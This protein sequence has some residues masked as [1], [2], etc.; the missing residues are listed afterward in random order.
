MFKKLLALMI[1][2]IAFGLVSLLAVFAL[3]HTAYLTPSAQWLNQQWLASPF[4]FKQVRYEYPLHITF[5]EPQW[6]TGDQPKLNAQQLDIWFHPS[7]Y[8]QGRWQ[9]RQLL[10]DQLQF[11]KDESL[12]DLELAE[13]TQSIQLHHLALERFSLHTPE[14]SIQE[15]NVQIKAPRWTQSLQQLPYGDIQLSATQLQWQHQ[16]LT[17]PLLDIRYQE[18]DSTVYGFSFRWQGGD[19]SGQAEHYPQGWS[20]INT[21][22]Q[23]LNWDQQKQQAL[24]PDLASLNAHI[25]HLNSLDILQSQLTFSDL[26][27]HNLSLSLE[28][29]DLRSWSSPISAS[30]FTS[31]SQGRFSFSA[32]SLVYQ[33]WAWQEL[34]LSGYFNDNQTIIEQGFAQLFNGDIQFSGALSKQQIRLEQLHIQGLKWLDE[35]P[36]LSA[37]TTQFN[38][39]DRIEIQQLEVNNLDII[40]LKASPFWQIS[41]LNIEGNQVVLTAKPHWWLWDGE[42]TL[43]ANQASF[44]DWFSTQGIIQM[45]SQQGDWSLDRAF[46]P[47][48]Q[49]YL[50]AQA[51]WQRTLNS[52]PW[53]LNLHSDG[54]ALAPIQYWFQLPLGL[55]GLADI[56]LEAQGLGGD[57]AMFAH[58][59]AGQLTLSLRDAQLSLDDPFAKPNSDEA[60]FFVQPIELNQAQISAQRGQIQLADTQLMGPKFNGLLNL[61]LDLLSPEQGQFNLQFRHEKSLNRPIAH[62]SDQPLDTELEPESLTQTPE[63]D[64]YLIQIELIHRQHQKLSC[65][66]AS[67]RAD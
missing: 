19:I 50:K 25:T 31:L 67:Q 34:N 63:P 55:T 3:L 10:I 64:C 11:T 60:Q 2:V 65:Q 30:S 62:I 40:S 33:Q 53:Q 45:H 36:E 24:M 20:L 16:I 9:I 61:N 58:S 38:E 46:L 22:I 14:L 41:G 17:K 13:L 57:Q 59:L 43:S 37:I 32:D 1:A 49:G 23:H 21:T 18:Q 52:M 39:L 54:L 7:I 47:F 26:E 5:T 6:K 12:L 29:I 44:G 15:A 4:S 27:L 51:Q 56:E 42:L 28:D 35:T 8:R 66:S 48:E